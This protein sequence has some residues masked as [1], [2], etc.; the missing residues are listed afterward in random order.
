MSMLKLGK[1]LLQL[2]ASHATCLLA[3]IRAK[4]RS[5]IFPKGSDVLISTEDLTFQ[6]YDILKVLAA[7]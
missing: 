4:S 6:L 2:N 5:S 3:S 7:D 1:S